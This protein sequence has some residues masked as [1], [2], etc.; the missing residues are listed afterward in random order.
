MFN[1]IAFISIFISFIYCAPVYLSEHD[2]SSGYL[3]DYAT[4]EYFSGFIDES[5]SP[6]PSPSPSP[7]PTLMN[8]EYKQFL[9]LFEPQIIPS[10][11]FEDKE[12]INEN[13]KTLTDILDNYEM[14]L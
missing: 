7:T 8:E 10:P 3:Y 5:L 11:S 2:Y 6:S 13:N 9:M 14:L 12:N 4:G 1:Y